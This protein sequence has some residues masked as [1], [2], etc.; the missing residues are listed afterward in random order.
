MVYFDIYLIRCHFAYKTSTETSVKTPKAKPS[1]KLHTLY[2]LLNSAGASLYLSHYITKLT[3]SLDLR[4]IRRKSGLV[5]IEPHH[6]CPLF[7]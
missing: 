6:L 5:Q 7:C 4:R 2:I 3:C 1:K